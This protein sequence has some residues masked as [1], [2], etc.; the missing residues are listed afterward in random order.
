MAKAA[1]EPQDEA[2]VGLFEADEVKDQE[3]AVYEIGYHLLPT[4]SESEV[5]STVKELMAVL[6]KNDATV[7]AD[8]EPAQIELAYA[9]E[10]RIAGRL[11]NFNEAF[12]GWVA[13]EVTPDKLGTL[14]SFLD[15]HPSI[16]RFILISTTA[17]EVKA[18]QEGAVIMPTAPTPTGTIG[19][20]KRA[21]EDTAVVSD[22][23]LSKAL[24]TMA[25][26]DAGKDKEIE[27]EG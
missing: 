11:T 7:I 2:L 18:V 20:S 10:K 4:L 1:I 17:E 5:T 8:G 27:K 14:K 13:F 19:A 3:A 25:D 9:I 21:A 23:A 12:F 24:D 6:K 26:E 16:L 15:M 22:E